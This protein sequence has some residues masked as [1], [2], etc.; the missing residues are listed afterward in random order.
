[1][2]RR[3]KGSKRNNPK[4]I[5]RRLTGSTDKLVKGLVNFGVQAEAYRSLPSHGVEIGNE[6]GQMAV[7]SKAISDRKRKPNNRNTKILKAPTRREL[8][9][10][11]AVVLDADGFVRMARHDEVPIGIVIQRSQRMRRGKATHY[12]SVAQSVERLGEIQD[13]GVQVPAGA[14]IHGGSSRAERKRRELGEL[15]GKRRAGDATEESGLV[16]TEQ[17]GIHLRPADWQR[18][19]GVPSWHEPQGT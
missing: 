18:E 17:G 15:Y 10:N 2:P 12:A 4:T 9:L 14:P 16:G 13:V 6:L 3:G 8:P 5:T 11:S 1:M 19:A 7:A